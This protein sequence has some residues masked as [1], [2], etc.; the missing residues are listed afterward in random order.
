MPPTHPCQNS[1]NFVWSSA[2]LIIGCVV[3]DTLSN[4]PMTSVLCSTA[5]SPWRMDSVR[6][7]G[8]GF[9]KCCF[10]QRVDVLTS[11][12]PFMKTPL[13]SGVR[14]H[15][16][17]PSPGQVS[18]EDRKFVAA[19]GYLRPVSANQPDNIEASLFFIKWW[20]II[21]GGWRC[22]SVLIEYLASP[23][24]WSP[25][26][27]PNKNQDCILMYFKTLKCL[28]EETPRPFPVHVL[29]HSQRDLDLAVQRQ[30]M[31]SLLPSVLLVDSVDL[32][33]RS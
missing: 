28:R 9:L 30:K 19:L 22:T 32:T 10:V 27:K 14:I 2:S 21:V 12:A 31:R 1:Y 17:N 5:G 8:G 18:Q 26:P 29:L 16:C 6:Y 15:M 25:A 11:P 33:M 24:I 13:F 20:K 23:W 4:P 3:L 7:T